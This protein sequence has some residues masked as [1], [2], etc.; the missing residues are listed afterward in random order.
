MILIRHA[1]S[2]LPVFPADAF[3][4]PL[5]NSRSRAAALLNRGS[6]PARASR[7]AARVFPFGTSG[8]F[9]RA[10]RRCTRT[11]E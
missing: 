1:A 6:L 5:F 4:S 7:M 3:Q 2:C 9:L 11:T 8:F 10:L